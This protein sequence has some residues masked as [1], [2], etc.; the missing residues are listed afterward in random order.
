MD[1]LGKRIKFAA[2]KVG[3]LETLAQRTNVKRTTMFYY[4]RDSTEP[5][6]STLIDI[7]RETGVSVE[8]LA[9]GTGEQLQKHEVQIKEASLNDVRKYVWNIAE[10]YWENLPRRTK[11]EEFADRFVAMLDYLLSREGL[12]PDA[13]S[14]VIQFDVERQKRSSD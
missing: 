7:A 6:V 1:T 9:V 14:E 5:K 11:P 8:W 3:G 4:A 13:A 10:T 2:E 12:Q